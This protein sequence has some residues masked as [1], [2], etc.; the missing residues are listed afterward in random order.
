MNRK[1]LFCFSAVDGV[2]LAVTEDE[3]VAFFDGFEDLRI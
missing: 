1:T 3:E 2:S